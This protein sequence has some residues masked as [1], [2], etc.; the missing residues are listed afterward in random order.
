MKYIALIYAN[1]ELEP[2]FGTPEFA[3]YMDG[4]RTCNETYAADGVMLGGEALQSVDVAT[5]IRVR[6]G[7]TEAMDGPFIETKE[8]LGGYYLLDCPD[9]D[10]A[11]RYAA[12]I[13]TAQF[14]SVE[15]RPIADVSGL[16]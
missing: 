4:Y 15:I 11:I 1:R 3:R 13:P 5:T 7:R 2:E 9:L 12:M 8:Q 6:N 16:V 14:G 10:T